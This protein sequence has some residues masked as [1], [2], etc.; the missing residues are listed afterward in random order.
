MRRWLEVSQH[1][2][3]R[4]R[5]VCSKFLRFLHMVSDHRRPLGGF[6]W[7]VIWVIV[8]Y[9]EASLYVKDA[10]ARIKLTKQMLPFRL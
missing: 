10:V 6:G 3:S 8:D 1:E 5:M 2:N 4:C 9:S 7:D